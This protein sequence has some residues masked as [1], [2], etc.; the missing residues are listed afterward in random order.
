MSGQYNRKEAFKIAVVAAIGGL[1]FGFDTGVISGALLLIKEQW[2]LGTLAQEVVTSAVLVGAILGAL[3]SGRVADRY[4]RKRVIIATAI[5]FAIGSVATALSPNAPILI[6]GRIVLGIAIGVASFTVPL[7]ISEVS[8]SQI[9]GSLVSLNQLMITIGIVVSYLVNFSL[10]TVD[11]GWRYMFAFGLIPSILLFVGMLFLPGSPR[12]LMSVGREEEAKASLELV[13]SEESAKKELEGIRQAIHSDLEKERVSYKELL[14]PYVRPVLLIGVGIMFF[15]QATGINTVIYYSPTILQMA[16]FG[17][18][19]DAMLVALPIGIVNVLATILSIYLI[20]RIGRKALLYIGVTGMVLSLFVL[21]LVFGMDNAS[22]SETMKYL[23][24]GSLIF[25]IASFG[26]S[27]GPVA[28]LLISEIFPVRVRNLGMS[29]ATLSNW[30]FN[31]IVA[32]TFLSI[33]DLIG[34]TGTFWLYATVGLATLWFIYRYIPETKGK[35]LEEIEGHFATGK[36][37]RDL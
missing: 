22:G 11:Q 18:P 5:I 10:A 37:A 29:V 2:H 23:A 24:V 4:G 32:L 34:A 8:P 26:I 16:G 9:R 13:Y 6:A 28:W 20:D 3:F 1:L 15:Q 31:L 27:L 12:W 21:G 36:L 14:S 7:Y 19:K 17:T 25:Y 33:V 30:F 35:T